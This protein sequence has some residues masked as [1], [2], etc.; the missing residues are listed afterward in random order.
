MSAVPEDTVS[1]PLQGSQNSRNKKQPFTPTDKSRERM[2]VRTLA[3]S[4]F[5]TLTQF[6]SLFQRNDDAHSGPTSTNVIKTL[7]HRHARQRR[8]QE[9]H[10]HL[11]AAT[12][13]STDR[14]SHPV[15]LQPCG[16]PAE[17]APQCASMWWTDGRDREM[18]QPEHCEKRWDWRLRSGEE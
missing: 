13:H 15:A 7:P 16:Q 6:R 18:E 8:V 17:G 1:P 10:R 14:R 12:L 3:L 2:N 4:C 9:S 11:L 5:S